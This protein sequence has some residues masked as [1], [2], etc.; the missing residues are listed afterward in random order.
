MKSLRYRCEGAPRAE[1]RGCLTGG[2]PLATGLGDLSWQGYNARMLPCPL[3]YQ[4]TS[5]FFADRLR[6]YHECSCCRLI[7]ADPASHVSPERE[8]ALYDLHENDPEDAGY[9]RF[10]GRLSVPLLARLAPGMAGL[11]YGSGPGPVLAA[12]LEDAGM[13]MS[14]YDPF[15][16]PD[17]GPLQ[18]QY[19]FLTCTEVVEHF[20]HPAEDWKGMVALVCPGGW[21]GIMTQLAISRERFTRWQ[22]KNDPSHVSFYSEATFAWLARHYRMDWER[23]G[24]D[25]I[26]M[27]KRP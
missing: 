25:V 5:A 12:M 4:T 22:Y 7:F 19:D 9:R 18:R 2:S 17:R 11:D 15:Y 3:C 1:I 14:V 13:V 16:A 23:L 20:R 6:T 8:K 26:L 10:L 21:L 27:R 24:R